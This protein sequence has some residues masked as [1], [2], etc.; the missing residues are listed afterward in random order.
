VKQESYQDEQR[1][2]AIVNAMAKIDYVAESKQ[3]INAIQ[4]Y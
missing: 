4:A 1:T 3:L 2:K